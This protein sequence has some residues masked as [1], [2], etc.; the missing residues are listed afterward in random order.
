M[1]SEVF[2]LDAVNVFNCNIDEVTEPVTKYL[3]SNELV[4]CDEPLITPDGNEPPLPLAAYLVSND[5]VN[6]DEPEIVPDGTALIL[7]LKVYRVS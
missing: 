1:F 4:N 6:C 7:P 5:A 3:P 2:A